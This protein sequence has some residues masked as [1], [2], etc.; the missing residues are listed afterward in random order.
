MSNIN[1]PIQP[2]SMAC[3]VT[4][5]THIC[6]DITSFRAKIENGQKPNFKAGQYAFVQMHD[7]EGKPFSIA[8]APNQDTFEFHIRNSGHGVSSY[9]THDLKLGE[10][11]QI[12][13]P[14]GDN[15]LRH[16]DKP[17]LCIAG[18][19]G[20]TPMKSIIDHALAQRTST[21][22]YIFY[23][24]KSEDELYLKNHF[25]E[26]SAKHANL[27]FFG[28]CDTDE[29]AEK[30]TLSAI[31]TKHVENLHD[32]QAYIAGPFGLVED[33]ANFLLDQGLPLDEMHSDAFQALKIKPK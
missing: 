32:C 17:V 24:A 20:I 13:A 12:T 30:M 28:I 4:E 26:Q 9:V 10:Q 19:L 16:L 11:I 8:C 31:L 7:F 6:Q 2:Q 5:I 15:Y 23:C 25:T 22:L 14:F 18:G 3:H 21:P 29:T 1:T 33:I 27:H